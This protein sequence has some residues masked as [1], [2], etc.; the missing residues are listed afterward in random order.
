[1]KLLTIPLPVEINLTK[2]GSVISL[3]KVKLNTWISKLEISNMSSHR[4]KS[5]ILGCI[6]IVGFPSITYSDSELIWNL[7]IRLFWRNSDM[8]KT[9]E[10]LTCIF[11]QAPSKSYVALPQPIARLYLFIFMKC[12]RVDCVY[13]PS[14][15]L[16]VFRSLL[17][18]FLGI[19]S[20]AQLIQ[21]HHS[22]LL[23]NRT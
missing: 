9:N 20:A 1:M 18:Y 13:Q 23:A 7:N 8:T 3:K 6:K 2:R 11:T 12:G 22:R 5:A 4:L 10:S 15:L 19:H 21:F 17:R 16:A 14:R